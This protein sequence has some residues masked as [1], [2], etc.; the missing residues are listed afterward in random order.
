MPELGSAEP[1]PGG[2]QVSADWGI[3][4][5]LMSPLPPTRDFL[6]EI[7]GE[8]LGAISTT[9]IPGRYVHIGG[10]ECVLDS[11]RDDPRI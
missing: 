9:A 5:N 11:W 6:A 8:L 4:P 3:F 7:F 10:D 1:P 2:Y